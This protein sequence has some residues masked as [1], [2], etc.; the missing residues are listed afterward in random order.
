M[1]WNLWGLFP[2]APYW[3]RRP[4]GGW[5]EAKPG[6]CAEKRWCIER[7]LSNKH[8]RVRAAVQCLPCGVIDEQDSADYRAWMN[9]RPKCARKR[10]LKPANTFIQK[11]LYPSRRHGITTGEL[12]SV[13][14]CLR[15]PCLSCWHTYIQFI[16]VS[17]NWCELKHNYTFI[18]DSGLLNRPDS[19]ISNFWSLWTSLYVLC[20]FCVY[21]WLDS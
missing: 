2:A 1:T 12:Q 16:P 13:T 15:Y 14:E 11:D 3:G 5:K 8:E 4:I 20:V 17:N 19:T 9:E 21:L 18:S 7:F 10:E 6:A